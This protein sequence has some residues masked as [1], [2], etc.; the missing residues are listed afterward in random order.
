V[1]EYLNNLEFYMHPGSSFLNTI[2]AQTAL[3]L[4]TFMPRQ[5]LWVDDDADFLDLAQ[6]AI[7]WSS[8]C[9]VTTI[10]DPYQVGR[11][12]SDKAFDLIVVDWNMPD[13]NGFDALRRVQHQINFDQLAPETWFERKTP[14]IVATV[15]EK[16]AVE[17]EQ[18]LQSSFQYL[19]LVDKRQ[20]L[21]NIIRDISTIYNQN[22]RKTHSISRETRRGSNFFS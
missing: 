3:Q 15:F 6:D 22:E 13:L 1:F 16:I 9:E 17:K 2:A 19:G 7:E 14:V 10:K 20:S 12:A 21:H 8:N 4:E 5:L 18:L 11:V